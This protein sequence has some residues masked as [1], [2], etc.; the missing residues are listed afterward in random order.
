M[1]ADGKEDSDER[2]PGRVSF[3]FNHQFFRWKNLSLNG[4][5]EF[6]YS[7]TA[8]SIPAVFYDED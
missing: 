8:G 7:A 2:N 4:K 5:M 3:A 1:S 6:C